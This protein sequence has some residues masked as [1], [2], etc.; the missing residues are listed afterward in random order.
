VLARVLLDPCPDAKRLQGRARRHAVVLALGHKFRDGTVVGAAR[1]GVA[2]IRREDF[3]EAESCVPGR[4]VGTVGKW[5]AGATA[6]SLAEAGHLSTAV[7][8]A[9]LR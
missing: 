8:I 1:V 4:G 6:Q 7:V 2:D 3:Q 9:D 5:P